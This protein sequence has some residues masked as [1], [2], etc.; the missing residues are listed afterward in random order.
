[1]AEPQTADGSRCYFFFEVLG[2]LGSSV[3]VPGP[4]G[5]AG[6]STAWMRTVLKVSSFDGI[7]AIEG[8]ALNSAPSAV[9]VVLRRAGAGGTVTPTSQ[10]Q[11]PARL[12]EG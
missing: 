6:A 8:I 5:L 2:G 3:V 10:A 1:M 12:S 11:Q 4:G 9:S 7:C